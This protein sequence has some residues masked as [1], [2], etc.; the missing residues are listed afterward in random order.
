MTLPYMNT[1]NIRWLNRIIKISFELF[2]DLN[3]KWFSDDYL[4]PGVD[5]EPNLLPFATACINKERKRVIQLLLPLVT[6]SLRT[7]NNQKIF[8]TFCNEIQS[9]FY[10]CSKRTKNYLQTLEKLVS[11]RITIDSL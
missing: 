9:L 6:S 5:A 3:I 2:A 10:N 8:Q 4:H 7:D 1:Q 11:S